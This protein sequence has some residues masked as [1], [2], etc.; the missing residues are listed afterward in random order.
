MRAPAVVL[1]VLLLAAGGLFAL[2]TTGSAAGRLTADSTPLTGNIT[3]PGVLAFNATHYYTI[4]ATGGPAFA[5]NGTQVGNLSYYASVTGTNLTG[6]QVNPSGGAFVN[7]R[8]QTPSLSVGDVAETVTIQIELTSVLGTVNDSLNL[9]YTVQVVQPYILTL[10]LIAGSSSVAAFPLTV[11]LDGTPVGSIAV[12]TLTANESYVATF[13][14]AT[15]SLSSGEHTFTVSLA[16]EHGLVQFSGGGTSYSTTFYVPGSPPNYTLW[17][18]A[19]AVAFFGAI[20][21]FV[22]RV[23]ARRRSPSRK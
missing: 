22:T 23:A 12:P 1:L 3:G 2:G 9:T 7:G 13:Q 15:L 17:Y 20:F 19:G 16:N 10:H 21:I 18:V 4:N 5:A 14:Y 11:F 6:V 8:G